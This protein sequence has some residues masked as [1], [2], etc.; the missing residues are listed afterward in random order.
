MREGSPLTVACQH[1][2]QRY[3]N[4]FNGEH[5]ELAASGTL[6]R[7]GISRKH[8]KCQKLSLSL[9]LALDRT[10]QVKNLQRM[11]K[12]ITTTIDIRSICKQTHT[13]NALTLV[14]TQCVQLSGV[15]YVCLCVCVCLCMQFKHTIDNEARNTSESRSTIA[16]LAHQQLQ[17]KK[18]RSCRALLVLDRHIRQHAH[19]RKIPTRIRSRTYG[20]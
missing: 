13:Y 4:M 12:A 6:T 9:S 16:K 2:Q 18:V 7:A 14:R 15:V 17:K 11:P 8:A 10:Q 3:D 5:T 1:K 20:T 19:V